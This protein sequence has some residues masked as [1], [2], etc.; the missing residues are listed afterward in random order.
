M[1]SIVVVSGDAGSFRVQEPV[2][3]ILLANSFEV[4]IVSEDS[5]VAK[6]KDLWKKSEVLHHQGVKLCLP[7]DPFDKDAQEYLHQLI[8]EADLVLSGTCGKAYQLE[9]LAFEIA[10]KNDVVSI[11]M[12]DGYY[13]HRYTHFAEINPNYWLAI[14][15]GHQRDIKRYNIDEPWWAPITGNPQFDEL[16]EIKKNSQDIR[17][18]VRQEL[19]LDDSNILVTWWTPSH[20]ERV[21][22][23]FGFMM[24]GL[25]Y[26]SSQC[27]GIYKA[28]FSPRIHPTFD[29]FFDEE[30][31]SNVQ[32]QYLYD[33]IADVCNEM[34]IHFIPS[35]QNGSEM[36]V[37]S[38][39]TLG[40]MTTTLCSIAPILGRPTSHL[41]NLQEKKI[42]QEMGLESP[43]SIMTK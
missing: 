20:P 7:L 19:G 42:A 33:Y 14:N 12:A 24:Q 41:F 13:N 22:A 10:T 37:A 39:I 32:S 15:N 17:Q 40:S 8:S 28:Y 23:Q 34:L 27:G 2:V 11:A 1:P 5:D 43:Y 26:L 25:N 21:L 6:A 36:A 16:A 3:K 38:D 30:P 35:N 31:G 29:S 9:K 4:F 18:K